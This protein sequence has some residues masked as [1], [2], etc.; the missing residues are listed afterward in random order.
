MVSRDNLIDAIRSMTG[1]TGTRNVCFTGGEPML[2][3]SFELLRVVNTLTPKGYTFEMFSNGTL[4][5]PKELVDTVS[6]VLDW[7]LTGSGEANGVHDEVRAANTDLMWTSPNPGRHA[8]KFTV[9][10]EFD[11]NEAHNVGQK[12][13][14][15]SSTDGGIV[16][17]IIGRVW[18]G[19]ITN[20]R[21]VDYILEKR[22][23]WR[24]SMQMH[25][26]I[27]DPQERAR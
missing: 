6:I 19:E 2:Q 20:A 11:L 25:N 12:H 9:R 15:N 10:D 23:P 13:Y 17:I 8:I 27:W 3:N 4:P 7:K 1:E 16:Q 21:I 24:L 5:Y 18:N 22:L 14:F 26:L